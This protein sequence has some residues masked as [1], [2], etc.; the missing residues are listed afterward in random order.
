MPAPTQPRRGSPRA[1]RTEW[2]KL[3]TV[4]STAW[5]LVAA[6]AALVTVSAA[7][8]ASVDTSSC[9]TP[10]ECFEDIPKLS[11]T[12]VVAAQAAVAILAVLAIT[13]EYGT[14]TIGT[15]LAATPR[16]PTVLLTKAIVVVG[17]VF[18]AA[19]LG[20]L[21][22]LLA[23]RLILP[24]S[25]F[26]SA[27]GYPPLSLADASTLRAAVGAVLYLVLV[28]LL[29]LGIA[30]AVRDTAAAITGVL[31]L[32]YVFPVL[33]TMVTDS[34]WQERFQRWGPA[35]AGQ[36]ILATRDLSDLPI[37]PWAGLG[38][39]AAYA[40]GAVVLGGLFLTH[41]DA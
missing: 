8:T 17:A 9:P 2:T 12:G 33:V 18:I 22:S 36:A 7:A 20:V 38:V 32:L 29:S 30:T 1:V 6:V 3:R 11:L 41:R 13:S 4:P 15:T 27:N 10:T 34:V 40:C 39:L 24:G 31:T 5:L 21:G 14:R 16:R 19:T 35:D 25:G 23:G 26:T 37:R 28:A